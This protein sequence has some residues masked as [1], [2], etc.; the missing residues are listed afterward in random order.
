MMSI[1]VE[2]KSEMTP[3]EVLLEAFTS[4]KNVRIVFKNGRIEPKTTLIDMYDEFDFVPSDEY[5][6]QCP[7]ID[8]EFCK[9]NRILTADYDDVETVEIVE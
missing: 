5:I 4:G 7:E 3:Y 6:A 2:R 8:I 1:H 9:I